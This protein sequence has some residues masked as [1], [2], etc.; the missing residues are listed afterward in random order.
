MI[1]SERSEIIIYELLM[2]HFLFKI[3]AFVFL[4]ISQII[5]QKPDQNDDELD[6]YLQ[7]LKMESL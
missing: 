7:S 1:K 4:V 3:N 6:S 5:V 2:K